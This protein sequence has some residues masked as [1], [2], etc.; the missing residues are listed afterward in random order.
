MH[1]AGAFSL[2][3]L[4]LAVSFSLCHYCAEQCDLVLGRTH[5]NYSV[6]GEDIMIDEWLLNYCLHCSTLSLPDDL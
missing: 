2:G 1:D 6:H 4:E 3:E 5:L